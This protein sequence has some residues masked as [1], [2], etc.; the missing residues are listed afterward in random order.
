MKEK[1]C[2]EAFWFLL[3]LLLLVVSPSQ[4]LAFIKFSTWF[5]RADYPKIDDK[6]VFFSLQGSSKGSMKEDKKLSIIHFKFTFQA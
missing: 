1:K 6:R 5:A 4:L 3:L 2:N